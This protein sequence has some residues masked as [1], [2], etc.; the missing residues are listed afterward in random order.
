MNKVPR[1]SCADEI[2]YKMKRGVIKRN[3]HFQLEV[4]HFPEHL[5]NV[6]HLKSQLFLR[7]S[8]WRL[9]P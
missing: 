6:A 2:V 4:D 7:M 8:H 9:L 3:Y 5:E 1:G